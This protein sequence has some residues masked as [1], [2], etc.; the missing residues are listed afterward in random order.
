M[1]RIGSSHGFWQ[2]SDRNFWNHLKQVFALAGVLL[3]CQVLR[4]APSLAAEEVAVRFGLF[5]QAVSISDLQQYA[6]TGRATIALRDFLRY[7]KRSDQTAL[8][9]A[10]QTQI[11]VSLVA[12]DRVLN[13]PV[14]E[15]FLTQLAQSDDRQDAAGV[16][17]LRAALILG[18]KS[19]KISLLSVLAAYPNHRVTINISE[20][21]RVLA[22]S[23][24]H[25]PQDQL[26]KIPAWQT[27]VAY[28]STVSQEQQ[29]QGC[30]FGDSISSELG[31]SFG[32][33]RFNFAIGGMSTVSLID[34]LQTLIDRRVRCQTVV[35]AIGTNDAWYQISDQQFKQNMTQVIA[36]ARS[37]SAQRIYVL[38][39]FYST[40]AA[41]QNPE[42]AGS[43]ERI[44][45]INTVLKAVTA[46]Q[47]VPLE[48][49]V[50]SPL[51]EQQALKESLTTDG[52]H[53]NAAGQAL[54]QT[55]L[56]RFLAVP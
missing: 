21:L 47:Q 53:L 48:A 45:Q 15:R 18:I 52:V 40:I 33:R 6:E 19:N 10:L 38:P 4:A 43:I 56:S 8:R 16:Q 3:S 27:L 32:E 9:Q 17:A 25:P 35:I 11:P 22:E 42:L 39:A 7:L 28:Q 2:M 23:T 31:N 49:T 5:T 29:Y 41:S 1:I 44:N 51:F 24:P 26:P 12:L 14:G 34:Q 55:I 37:L 50:L 36:L 20:A 54:Y 30:L 46:E 13:A